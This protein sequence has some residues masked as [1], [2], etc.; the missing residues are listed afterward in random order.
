MA[1]GLQL[2]YSSSFGSNTSGPIEPSVLL[3]FLSSIPSGVGLTF[4]GSAANATYWNSAGKLVAGGVNTPRFETL[5]GIPK[6]LLMEGARTNK[7]TNQNYNPTVTTGMVV[8][9]AGVL[10]IVSDAAILA[11][12]GLDLICTS[13]NVFY[14]DNSAGGSTSYV[15]IDAS[16]GNTNVHS[17]SVYARSDAVGGGNLN[18]LG[19][20]AA[21]LINTTTSYSRVT[22]DKV[23]PSGTGS[24]VRV[25]ALAGRKVWFVL[26]Q[27]EEATFSSSVIL[28]A[29]A[30]ATR[31]A[32]KLTTTLTALG[33][34]WNQSSGGM[35]VK[36][37]FSNVPTAA[38]LICIAS[39]GTTQETIGL[40]NITD[41]YIRPLVTVGNQQ[42]SAVSVSKVLLNQNFA[43]A[44][45][46]DATS[47]STHTSTGRRDLVTVPIGAGGLV[48]TTALTRL[49]IGSQY[50]G[51]SA[52]YGHI[53]QI[54]LFNSKPSSV[55]I[56]P[57]IMEPSAKG[58]ATIG[59]SLAD[60]LRRSNIELDNTGEVSAIAILNSVWTSTVGNNWLVHGAVAGAGALKRNTT[61]SAWYYD[62]LTD[63]WGDAWDMFETAVKQ[64]LYSGGRIMGIN[65]DQGQQDS[66]AILA[67]T[68]TVADWQNAWV[69]IIA[70]ARAMLGNIPVVI[71]PT[72]GR[73]DVTS[74]AYQLLREAQWGL[75]A[76]IPNSYRGPE[77]FDLPKGAGDP[78]HL[79]SAGYVTSAARSTRKLLKVLGETITGGVDGPTATTAVRST[80]TVTVTVAHEA[81]TD[82]T[83]TTAIAGFHYFDGS[84]NEIAIT[85]AV[86][87][88]ATTI[89]LTL[90]S[91]VAG[92]LYYGYDTLFAEA[93]LYANL[94][95]DNSAQDMPL[96]AAKFTVT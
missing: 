78:V 88:N 94:V 8:T 62:D 16:V 59:Q 74:G 25:S 68:C 12:S 44:L 40:R 26:N 89:T 91:A 2:G 76:L 36:G 27:L 69:K 96:R 47:F 46:W 20:A 4:T 72:V 92:T 66:G 65:L 90:A 6:G 53:K 1:L 77:T 75:V 63:T 56:A 50:N 38:Q 57:F 37:D 45:L 73:T 82:F 84:G 93:A 83:P 55:D 11:S 32:D 3:D 19:A 35:V 14:L 71:M 42:Q 51:S 24:K 39:N 64:F 33:S 81:G 70:K 79:N 31:T 54:T 21:S 60:N 86:R 41:G 22:L 15:E 29:G 49:D 48:P 95:K 13:G 52:L 61:G 5:L 18:L 34:M 43:E 9:G 23:T 87:T 17:C 28:T 30:S 58:L 67:G 80:N 10:S 7:H 85:S